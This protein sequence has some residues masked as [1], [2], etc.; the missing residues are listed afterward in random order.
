MTDTRACAFSLLR[1]TATAKQDMHVVAHPPRQELGGCGG[2]ASSLSSVAVAAVVLTSHMQ[3][4]LQLRNV[5]LE[6]EKQQRQGGAWPGT[7]HDK[8]MQCLNIPLKPLVV[9]SSGRCLLEQ[10]HAALAISLA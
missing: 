1:S 8:Q 2:I 10:M 5:Q 4:D 7:L 6:E 3:A 9:E